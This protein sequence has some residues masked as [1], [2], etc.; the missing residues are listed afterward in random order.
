MFLFSGMM[1]LRLLDTWRVGIGDLVHSLTNQTCGVSSQFSK[2]TPLP[3]IHPPLRYRF[4]PFSPL[5]FCKFVAQLSQASTEAKTEAEYGPK[6]VWRA[7][8]RLSFR[9]LGP[10]DTYIYFTKW[11]FSLSSLTPTILLRPLE[12]TIRPV[13]KDLIFLFTYYKYLIALE[14]LQLS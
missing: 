2:S 5:L 4:F 10:L 9:P 6:L 8:V 14:H 12:T 11:I 7:P 13:T 3:L 1:S